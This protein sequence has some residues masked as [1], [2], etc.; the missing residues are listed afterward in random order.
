MPPTVSPQRS[1][2]R[3][4]LTALV[5]LAAVWLLVIALV[6]PGGDFPL[7]DDWAYAW[8]ARHLATTGEL[9]ILD[10]AA[11]SLVT[12]IAWGALVVRIFGPSYVALR[13]GT[14]AW[15]MAGLVLLYAIGRRSQLGVARALLLALAVGLSPWYV[16]L[17]FS[18]MSDVPWLVMVLAALA[19]ALS[20]G[21]KIRWHFFAGLLLGAAALARQF[22]VVMSPAVLL[23]IVVDARAAAPSKWLRR[24]LRDSA[25]FL[26]PLVILVTGFQLWY[27]HVHGPTIANRLTWRRMGGL[28]PLLPI[29]HTLATWHYV[30]LWCAPW[31]LAVLVAG[32]ARRE[33]SWR[34]AVVAT[35]ALL[36]YSVAA[37]LGTVTDPTPALGL[38][39]TLPPTMPYLGN[40]VY[41]LGAGPLTIY[42]SYIGH[43][44]YLHRPVALG[45]ALS[46]VTVVCGV[47][48]GAWVLRAARSTWRFAVHAVT[49]DDEPRDR[50]RARL[51]LLTSSVIYLG[52]HVATGS[53]VFDR[54]VFPLMPAVVWIALDAAPL[55]LARS[56]VAIAAIAVMA[57]FSVG[58]TREYLGWNSARD[59]AVRDL[60][61]RGVSADGIDGG[62]EVNGPRHFSAYLA[63]TGRLVGRQPTPW[64]VGG[65]RWR[66]SFWPTSE[67]GCT[68]AA[69]YPFWSWPGGG[70]RAI[71]VIDCPASVRFD[72]PPDER[73]GVQ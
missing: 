43:A 69:E 49:R 25:V 17:S 55:D 3:D 51:L 13:V 4:D 22:A 24:A 15:G 33:V 7:N 20:G 28:D 10:W 46:G 58:A 5:V 14:L 19:A 60:E 67:P 42:E 47:I 53:I 59:H 8:S 36:G 1:P 40:L 6:G 21:E 72:V 48:A 63:R 34:V 29:A 16:N 70:A 68:T 45:W 65:A 32:R 2:A 35:L 30:G 56:R 41:I 39:A 37:W 57:I 62:F 9:R 64:W 27:G 44:P 38:N 52:W 31:A 71:R 50:A 12:H 54:Y 66:I 26:V 23:L 11:P 61:A 73:S 18:Y